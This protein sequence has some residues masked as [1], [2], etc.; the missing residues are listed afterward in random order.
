MRTRKKK[1]GRNKGREDRVKEEKEAVVMGDRK[2]G[3]KSLWIE[4]LMEW[5]EG[6]R[7]TDE[8]GSFRRFV[9]VTVYV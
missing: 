9:N 6:K 7:D 4:E 3:V 2:I 8:M 5:R 1:V